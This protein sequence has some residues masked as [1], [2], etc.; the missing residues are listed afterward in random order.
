[1]R[2]IRFPRHFLERFDPRRRLGDLQVRLLAAG[3]AR[4]NGL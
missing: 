4:I 2:I 1:M 3:V